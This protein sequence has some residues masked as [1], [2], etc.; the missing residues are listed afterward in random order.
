MS[1][2]PK[3]RIDLRLLSIMVII[4]TLST[5]LF[6]LAIAAYIFN[7]TKM[8]LNEKAHNLAT[9]ANISLITPIWDTNEEWVKHTTDAIILDKDVV[10]VRVLSVDK[11]TESEIVFQKQDAIKALS[12][13]DLKK[14]SNF[15]YASQDIKRM[16]NT[17][18]RVELIVSLEKAKKMI[19]DT[20]FM[21]GICAFISIIITIFIIGITVGK[22]ISRPLQ[23]LKHSAEELSNGNLDHLIDFSRE[24]EFGRL[25]RTFAEMRDNIKNKIL[26]IESY[27]RSLEEK[28]SERTKELRIKTNDIN[29]M[30]QNIRQGI[31]TIIKGNII[32]HEYSAFLENILETKDISGCSLTDILLLDTDLSSDDISQIKACIEYSINDNELNF[33]V[34]SHV[35]PNEIKKKFPSGSE[36]I[37]ELEWNPIYNEY[38]N[39][40][41]II[42]TVRDVTELK[43]LRR[44]SETQKKEL[45]IIDEILNLSSNQF[46]SF[47]K[48]SFNLIEENRQLI[49]Q[50]PIRTDTIV[51]HLFRNMHTLKGNS[52]LYGLKEISSK[53]HEVEQYY[54][55]LRENKA[56]WDVNTL[57]NNLDDVMAHINVYVDINQKKLTRLKHNSKH[58]ATTSIVKKAITML[59]S[60]YEFLPETHKK[61]IQKVHDL[62]SNWESKGLDEILSDI[63][64]SLPSLSKE[65]NKNSPILDIKAE[66]FLIF[67]HASFW[68]QDVFT[69]II[70]NA[71][72]HGIEPPEE[73]LKKGKKETGYISIS[74]DV[75]DDN[76]V[77]DIKD[78][79]RGLNLKKIREM[80]QKERNNI[81]A[82][83]L[84]DDEIASNIFNPG[85]S[86][87]DRVTSL[88]GRGV[89]L[90]VV[91]MS[92]KEHG[93]SVK[94]IFDEDSHEGDDFRG[95]LL[96]LNLPGDLFLDVREHNLDIEKSAQSVA[97]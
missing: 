8:S 25:A 55:L 57:L 79:G 42:V 88:S 36:K 1:L 52:R 68:V 63:F 64:G 60:S 50:N 82:S 3:K 81:K 84:I 13:D 46:D 66:G 30:L 96:R 16:E 85:F 71:I 76:L 37:L 9:L 32:H 61:S 11:K 90:D 89:G 45:L 65:L 40:E 72:D 80:V 28:V 2:Y 75:A 49:K 73:R 41:K 12:I 97:A 21:L 56:P 38:R 18:G 70:R 94:L 10:G 87:A 7:D 17:I 93:G 95:F 26:V 62:L 4:I 53:V 67:K 74:A 27:N 5:F 29:A 44:S 92:M 31:F 22:V 54:Q 39:V 77:I 20:S 14:N 15:V 6:T 58:K 43:D 78:D 23:E 19:M 24:D 47:L 59:N 83:D 91:F 86:T 35:L 34:N 69:H 48:N 51:A 33:L